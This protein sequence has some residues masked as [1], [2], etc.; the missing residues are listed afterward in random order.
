MV[1]QQFPTFSQ[2]EDPVEKRLI[3]KGELYKEKKQI[4]LKRKQELQLKSL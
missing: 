4:K 3:E 1:K 2:E